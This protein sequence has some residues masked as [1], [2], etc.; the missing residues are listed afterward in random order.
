MEEKK[1]ITQEER[2]QKKLSYEELEMTAKQLAA[3]GEAV[4]RENQKLKETIQGMS[5]T[6]VYTELEFRFKVLE[7]PEAFSASFYDSCVAQIEEIMTPHKE[8]NKNEE[9][10]D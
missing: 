2:Q 7:H 6:N 1:S 10:E 8:E 4:I 3:Q 9:Q 5:M